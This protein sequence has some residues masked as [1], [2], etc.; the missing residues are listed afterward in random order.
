MTNMDKDNMTELVFEQ[1]APQKLEKKLV[2]ATENPNKIRELQQLLADSEFEILS[3][4]DFPEIVLPPEDGK[5]FLENAAVK[6]CH[7]ARIT[8]LLALA[9]DSG[10]T[11][12]AL[13]GAPGVYSARFAGENKDSAANNQKLLELLA[14][15]SLQER[16]AAF[17]CL[18]VLADCR[19]EFMWFEGT[20]PGLITDRARGTNGFGY[21]PIFLLPQFDKTMA[22]LSEDEKNS[23]SHRGEALRKCLGL[24]ERMSDS[25][26]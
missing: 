2:L 23:V 13:D 19:D 7:V 3:L 14:G 4:Q 6:A 21:D 18:L 10:L 16:S 25:K 15:K 5:T 9:D 11:V 22:E 26:S 24:M 12:D 17:K 20:C 1:Q 8:G